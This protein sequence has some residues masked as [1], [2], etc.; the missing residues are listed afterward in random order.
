MNFRPA[1][2]DKHQLVRCSP[3]ATSALAIALPLVSP[4]RSVSV[5]TPSDGCLF[6]A[7]PWRTWRRL[8]D[9]SV[10][11]RLPRKPSGNWRVGHLTRSACPCAVYRPLCV[12]YRPGAPGSVPPTAV[13]DGCPLLRV[14][15]GHCGAAAADEVARYRPQIRSV[16]RRWRCGRSEGQNL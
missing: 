16:G 8:C 1:P 9:D 2:S 12:V 11:R 14:S 3:F 7:A 6:T 15:P 5:Y 13:L 10:T 4:C